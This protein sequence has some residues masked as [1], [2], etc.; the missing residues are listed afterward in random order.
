VTFLH[1]SCSGGKL[2]EGILR[3]YGG[4]RKERGELLRPQ[5]DELQDLVPTRSIDALVVSIGGNDVGFAKI[6]IRCITNKIVSCTDPQSSASETFRRGIGQLTADLPD[7]RD[8]LA[9][10]FG[11]RLAQ[12]RIVLAGY[13]DFTRDQNGD[14]CEFGRSSGGFMTRA[15]WRW[16][17]ERLLDRLTDVV[18]DFTQRQDP[19]WAFGR[20]PAS[21]RT[22][23]YCSSDTWMVSLSTT[24]G[25]VGDKNGAFHPNAAGQRAMG[26][27]SILPALRNWLVPPAP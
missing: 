16:A 7:F 4:V 23:G 26:R 24:F 14:Y 15:E 21:F 11:S 12:D 10:R 6:I 27:S 17:S 2:S 18:E 20:A 5:I 25:A 3:P 9:G 19:A 1:L 13:P 8:E 22:H